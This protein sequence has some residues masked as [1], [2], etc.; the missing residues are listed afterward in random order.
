MA[1]ET[2]TNPKSAHRPLSYD[3]YSTSS[4]SADSSEFSNVAVQAEALAADVSSGRFDDFEAAGEDAAHY[5]DYSSV[6]QL[7]SISSNMND[8]ESGG[9]GGGNKG[10]EEGVDEVLLNASSL[11]YETEG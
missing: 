3:N 6:P 11:K 2:S 8:E 9:G 10:N 4:S 1:A 5:P 7:P